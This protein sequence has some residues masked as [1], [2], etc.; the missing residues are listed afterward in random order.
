MD[1]DY[2]SSPNQNPNLTIVKKAAVRFDV[3]FVFRR[4]LEK[5][6]Q[7]LLF[8]INIVLK[9]VGIFTE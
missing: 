5:V 4:F 8:I 7:G 9:D 6:P 1:T 3:E 2:L